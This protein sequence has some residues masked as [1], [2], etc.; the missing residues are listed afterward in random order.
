[1]CKIGTCFNECGR[2]HAECNPQPWSDTCEKGDPNAKTFEE[3]K[4]CPNGLTQMPDEMIGVE[5]RIFCK[6]CLAAVGLETIANSD[7][8]RRPSG[9]QFERWSEKKD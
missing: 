2:C 5:P 7:G 8:K 9:Y 1:M 4:K 3:L 6:L